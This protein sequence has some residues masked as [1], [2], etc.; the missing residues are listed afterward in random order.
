MFCRENQYYVVSVGSPVIKLAGTFK[1]T[2]A[3]KANTFFL[4]KKPIQVT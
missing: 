1:E 3:I 2:A 4:Q